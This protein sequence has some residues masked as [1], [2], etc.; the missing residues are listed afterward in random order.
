MK[1]F[2]D[3]DILRVRALWPEKGVRWGKGRQAAFE[4][5]LS[6]LI[7]LAGVSTWQFEDGWLRT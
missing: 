4:A 3:D 1:A 6:R 7:R 2:R 5:E